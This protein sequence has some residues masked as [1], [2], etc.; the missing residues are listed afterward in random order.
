MLDDGLRSRI[1]VDPFARQRFKDI[2]SDGEFSKL[3]AVLR[4]R[5]K[6]SL[7][8]GRACFENPSHHAVIFH[9]TNCGVVGRLPRVVKLDRVHNRTL[10]LRSA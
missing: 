6:Q 8:H 10:R 4:D 7:L 3:L 2:L 1:V 5:T 9:F